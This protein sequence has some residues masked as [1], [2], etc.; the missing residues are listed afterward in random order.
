MSKYRIVTIPVGRHWAS[1]PFVFSFLVFAVP[2]NEL[3]DEN[4][5]KKSAN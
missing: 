3:R 2:L 1:P 4:T 5:N